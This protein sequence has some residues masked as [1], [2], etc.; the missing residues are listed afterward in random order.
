MALFPIDLPP[1]VAR[2]GTILQSQGRYYDADLVRWMDGTLQPI[3]GW[4]TKADTPVS[5]K[6]RAVLVWRDNDGVAWTAVGTHSNLYIMDR[7]G[8]VS[9]IT[10]TGYLV[11]NPD[12]TFRGG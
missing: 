12:S 7:A 10:P 4:R 1:G 3:K 9:D 11:G 8:G 2:G 6:A 5:G